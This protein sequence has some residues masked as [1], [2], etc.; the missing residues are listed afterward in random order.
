MFFLVRHGE[1]GDQA[2]P[3][4]KAKIEIAGDV[5]LTELGHKQALQTG[6]E[7]AKIFS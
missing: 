7:I 6:E 1:R 2:S 4:E 5:H 3:E